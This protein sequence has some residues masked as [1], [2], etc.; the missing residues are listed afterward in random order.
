MDNTCPWTKGDIAALDAKLDLIVG[1]LQT[2]IVADGA[3]E[4]LQD[5]SSKI[6]K[7]NKLI[8]EAYEQNDKIRN[9]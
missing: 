7:A 1:L 5:C 3:T 8:E 9:P 2:I 6:Q 4:S